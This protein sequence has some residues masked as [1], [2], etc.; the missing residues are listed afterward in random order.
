MTSQTLYQRLLGEDFQKLPPILQRFHSLP[1]GGKAFGSVSV[2]HGSNIR[3][4]Q[5]LRMQAT[6]T[7]LQLPPQGENIP[8]SLEVVSQQQ[9]ERELWIRRFGAEGQPG[10][11]CLRTLQW[12]EDGK[13][14]IEQA[15]PLLFVFR[16][17]ADE[18]GMT[19]HFQHNRL[20]SSPGA[21]P[22]FSALRVEAAASAAAA[23]MGNSNGCWHIQ[24]QIT[25]PRFGL[26]T[27]YEGE[28][29][30]TL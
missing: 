7:L 30:P 24:V 17:S 10:T 29:T 14:L 23:A 12:Q 20:R 2:K 5:L 25:S 6:R 8:L 11:C 15:G 4:R 13:Y 1:H 28:V 18:A 26:L 3:L 16:V 9:G 27:A 19:F 21:A 22:H